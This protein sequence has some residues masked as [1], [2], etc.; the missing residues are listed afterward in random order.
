MRPNRRVALLRTSIVCALV[1][2]SL[3]PGHVDP[4]PPVQAD[5]R[6]V[7]FEFSE[8]VQPE[9]EARELA[10][11][12]H[13]L[14]V[15]DADGDLLE[16]VLFGT[17]EANTL[18]GEGWYGNEASPSVGSFQ[19]AGG[20][21][22]QAS[23]Q[24]LLPDQA[25]GLLLNVTSV[26]DSLWM[27]VTV[28]GHP[29]VTLRIDA[30]WHSG[31]VPVA[32]AP[33][34]P[35][36]VGDPTWTEGRYFP[37][38]PATT[39]VDVIRVHTDL[40]NR[41]FAWTSGFRINAS[42][43]T[44]MAL[45]LVGMEGL[46]NRHGPCVYLDWTS[47]DRYNASRF[48]IPL[49]RRHVEVRYFDL[50]GLSAVRFL[51]RRYAA[52]FAGAVIYDPA[53]PD[54]INLATM[55]AGL[56]DRLILA[57]D[58]V[59]LPGIPSFAS[60]TDLRQLVADQGWNASDA[61]AYQL[62]HWVYDHLWPY[63][64]HRIL[65]VVS[66]GPPRSG[67][68]APDTVY[69]LGLGGRDY[70]VALRLPA[71]WLSPLEEP[72]ASLF[73]QFM[74]DA[75]SP[76]PLTG[77]FGD[78]EVGTVALASQHGNWVAGITHP[79]WDSGGGG[80]LTV[81]SG[82]RPDVAPY[83]A[84]MDADRLF[85]TLGTAPVATLWSSDGDNINYQLDRGFGP[86]VMTWEMAQGH[87]FGW[88]TNP[89]LVDLAPLV[90]NYYMESMNNTSLVSG[91]SGCGYMYP[92]RMNATQLQGYLAYAARYLNLTGLRA[93]HVPHERDDSWYPQADTYYDGLNTTGYLGAFLGFSAYP[94]SL[95]PSFSYPGGPAPAVSPFYLLRWWNREW[96]V[97]DLL[98][99]TPGE[100]Y[101][102]L[103]AYPNHEGQVVNDTAACDGTAVLF[104][105][106]ELPPCCLV[107]TV[108]FPAL[109]AGNYTV[110]TCLK[111]PNNQSIDPVVQLYSGYAV[112]DD[113]HSLASRELAPADFATAGAYQNFTLTFTLNETLTYNVEFM[114]DYFGNSPGGAPV[115][116]Y[117]DYVFTARNASPNVPI[118]AALFLPPNPQLS[119]ALEITELFE[120][121]GIV[122]LHPDEF[123]AALNPAFMLDWATPILGADHPLLTQARDHLVTGDYFDSLLSIR[124]ALQTLPTRAY[125]VTVTEQGV[126]Y[127]VTVTANTWLDPLTYNETGHQLQLHTHGPPEGTVHANIT[128][129]TDLLDGFSLVRVDHQPHP[130]TLTA[131]ATHTTVALTF[132]QG[133]HNVAVPLP[134]FAPPTIVAVTQTPSEVQLADTVHINA[135]VTDPNGVHRVVLNYTYTTPSTPMTVL[136]NMTAFDGD[137]WT[138]TIPPLPYHTNVTY[139]IVAED[140]LHNTVSTEKL[141]YA[142]H[143]LV[144]PEISEVLLLSLILAVLTVVRIGTKETVKSQ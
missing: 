71:L 84:A 70:L 14:H 52:R 74:A 78:E 113:W 31:Y 8:V 114:I 87:R 18:Q 88:T 15:L 99:R 119:E 118:F 126:P 4:S 111:V 92:P 109:Q 10:V 143:Y 44:M 131:N 121:A 138:A 43:T 90:W 7:L 25:D 86:Y 21:T 47:Q 125:L 67:Q 35:P 120:A 36:P 142:Y 45:T 73:A 132:P 62:Y 59:G 82:V 39:R 135:T 50:D 95:S 123:L 28:D 5:T 105:R 89:T 139:R 137:V 77:V 112:G 80:S 116:L 40:G 75:P 106:P 76:I 6:T 32:E 9:G 42:Y 26:V 33:S 66:P 83:Q 56:E 24:L 104:T 65:G 51:Y 41:S 130:V 68:I 129:P 72:Q 101:I 115:D 141:G 124:R 53:V 140:T 17:P 57:P 144:I 63:L 133:P 3:V 110:I 103:T 30:Y 20:A 23:M 94:S 61:S 37:A 98:A 108:I 91:L 102:D 34:T 22:R 96:I 64:E 100:E 19:W 122:V 60:V 136:M 81:L 13:A 1:I 128:L 2:V 93:V 85:A 55:L 48:W 107:T 12:F 38:F 11:A 79:G 97:N 127:N 58:Q 54:T 69:P 16:T 49:L 46:I 29:T 134:M 117:A 27:N